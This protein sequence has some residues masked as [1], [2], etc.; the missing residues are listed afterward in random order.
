[1]DGEF[2]VVLD[3]DAQ[4]YLSLNPL[5][6]RV[7][8]GLDA[9]R[10]PAQIADELAR[11]H[12]EPFDRVRRDVDQLV[13]HLTEAG[14]LAE[15]EAVSAPPSPAPPADQVAKLPAEPGGWW[16][17]LYRLAAAWLTLAAVDLLVRWRGS[18][19]WLRVLEERYPV[20]HGKVDPTAVARVVH[21]VDRAAGLYVKKAW[22][23]E[24]SLA[25]TLLLRRAGVPARLV[26]GARPMPFF[27]HAWVEVGSHIV[28]GAEWVPGLTVL[29]R[30]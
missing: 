19:W 11:E 2:A 22:C 20:R 30:F 6:T 1:M 21:A 17:R 26:L 3:L 28:S 23:L 25:I 8:Q 27:A 13:G 14:V 29:E 9:G 4:R 5:G 15:G 16:V 7:W 24:H 10:S 12:D 18:G